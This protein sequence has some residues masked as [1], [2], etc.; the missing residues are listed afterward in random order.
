VEAGRKATKVEGGADAA[1]VRVVYCEGGVN[2]LRSYLDSSHLDRLPHAV[3]LLEAAYGRLLLGDP[4]AAK[5]LIARSLVAPDREPGYADIPWYARGARAVGVSYRLDLAVA[6]IA[7]GDRSSAERELDTVLAMVNRMIAAGVQRQATFALR[8]KVYALKGQG[9]D[10]MRDLGKAVDLG[11]HSV[12]WAQH[13]PYL[14]SL[15]T[16]QDFQA[17]MTRVSQSNDEL[18]AQVNADSPG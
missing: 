7:L 13:E 8:A 5:E 3:A 14:A 10:A 17:L 12:W 18:I 15:R 1:M 2:A 6:E 9:D 16:R 4:V 11:W